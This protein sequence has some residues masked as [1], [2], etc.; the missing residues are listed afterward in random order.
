VKIIQSSKGPRSGVSL[1]GNAISA[2]LIV[3]MLVKL[4][5]QTAAS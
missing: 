5:K 3:V 4:R 2:L 1:A